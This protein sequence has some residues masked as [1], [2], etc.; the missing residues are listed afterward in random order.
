MQVLVHKQNCTLHARQL[1]KRNSNYCT[2]LMSASPA[3]GRRRPTRQRGG[4]V[5]PTR[6][7]GRCPPQQGSCRSAEERGAGAQSDDTSATSPPMRE[8]GHTLKR[9]HRPALLFFRLFHRFPDPKN[10]RNSVAPRL[11]RHSPAALPRCNARRAKRKSVCGINP[12][13]RSWPVASGRCVSP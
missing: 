9:R 10:H 3:G 6:R 5:A 1:F 4:W 11:T 7:R 8:G 13:S 2:R 12:T